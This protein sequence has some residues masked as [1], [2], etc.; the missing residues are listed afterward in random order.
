MFSF[1]L[2][3]AL[4]PISAS[5]RY[6]RGTIFFPSLRVEQG[7]TGIA[8]LMG[9]NLFGNPPFQEKPGGFQTTSVETWVANTL[10]TGKMDGLTGYAKV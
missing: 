6:S 8:L 3:S 2:S 4:T 7:R 1:Y 9:I 10:T 5:V